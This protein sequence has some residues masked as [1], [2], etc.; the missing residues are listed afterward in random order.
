MSLGQPDY[1]QVK[2]L[3]ALIHHLSPDSQIYSRAILE[4]YPGRD[5]THSVYIKILIHLF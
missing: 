1:L 4:F 5:K 2:D 3:K